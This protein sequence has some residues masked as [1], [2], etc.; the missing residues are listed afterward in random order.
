LNEKF[1]I[2]DVSSLTKLTTKFINCVLFDLHTLEKIF[3]MKIDD[4]DIFLKNFIIE[5]FFEIIVIL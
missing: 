2:I 4:F 1:I 5:K 3:E